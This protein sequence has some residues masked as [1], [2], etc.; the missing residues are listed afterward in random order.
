LNAASKTVAVSNA[1]DQTTPEQEDEEKRR[2]RLIR[3]CAEV[4][5]LNNVHASD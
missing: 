4:E 5:E 1:G 2:C 3:G